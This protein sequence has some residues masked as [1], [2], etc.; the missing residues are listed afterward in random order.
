MQYKEVPQTLIKS[1][2]S[3]L[4]FRAIDHECIPLITTLLKNGV[5]VNVR[6]EGGMTPLLYASGI[7]HA[8]NALL[9]VLLEFGMYGCSHV[10][11]FANWN[12]E[13]RS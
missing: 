5:D 13:C 7:C 2:G 12:G 8:S 4:L 10:S 9:D 3:S 11:R 6:D 1:H